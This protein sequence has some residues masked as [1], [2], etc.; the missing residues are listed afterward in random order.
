MKQGDTSMPDGGRQRRILVVEDDDDLRETLSIV[1]EDYGYSVVTASSIDVALAEVDRQAFG[2]ILSDLLASGKGDLLQSVDQ[3]RERAFPTPVGIV[4]GWRLS[5]SD[6]VHR[7]FAWLMDKPFDVDRLVTE[8]AARLETPLTGGEQRQAEVVHA[9]FAALSARDWD[10]LA[11]LCTEDVVY[12]LPSPAPFAG[13]VRGKQA[14]RR[15]TEDTYQHFPGAR[16]DEVRAYAL[17]AGLVARYVGRWPSAEG[18]LHQQA[19]AVVFRFE[20]E[21]I[22]Q[23]GIRLNAQQLRALLAASEERAPDVEGA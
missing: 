11:A 6:V 3:L 21:R 1:L 5:E 19:G 8:I 9:Y 16:F 17:P 20:G 4:T 22:K 14:F 15:Y 18:G 10:A 12:V 2:F 23:I 13:E 7:G